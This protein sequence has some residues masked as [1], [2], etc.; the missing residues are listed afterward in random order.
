MIF[1]NTPILVE[2]LPQVE[3]VDYRP[4]APAWLKA[5]YIGTTIFFTFLFLLTLPVVIALGGRVPVLYALPLLW[6]L[7]LLWSLWLTR[8]DF[9]YRGYGLRQKDIIYRKGVIFQSTTAIPFNRVQHVEIKQG[10]IA[11]YFGLH[12]LEV[13]T[14]GGESSDL[15]IPGLEGDTAQRLKTYIIHQTTEPAD[16]QPDL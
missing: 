4:L 15:S 11:R 3:L 7:L 1:S 6:V 8:K 13:Y 16:E 14:A 5:S 9:G 10:P 2:Q 12:T